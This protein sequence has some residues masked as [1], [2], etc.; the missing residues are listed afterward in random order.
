MRNFNRN[1]SLFILHSSL[2]IIYIELQPT[3]GDIAY[4]QSTHFLV[5]PQ[6]K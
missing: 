6:A 5:L 1:Y 2:F 3:L 4:P